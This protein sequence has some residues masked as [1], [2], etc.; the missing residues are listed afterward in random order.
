M[1]EEG[2]QLKDNK[3]L[4]TCKY[5]FI[6]WEDNGRPHRQQMTATWTSATVFMG[7]RN[8]NLLWITSAALEVIFLLYYPSDLNNYFIIDSE[9]LFPDKSHVLQETREKKNTSRHQ[10]FQI[11]WTCS[12]QISIAVIRISCNC[13]AHNWNNTRISLFT[14]PSTEPVTRA[15]MLCPYND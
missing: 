10:T 5:Q 6:V 14:C 2:G 7:I 4:H 1:G 8:Q 12:Y 13:V 15:T 11:N 3:V 9:M